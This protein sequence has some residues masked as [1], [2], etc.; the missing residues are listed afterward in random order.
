MS[1]TAIYVSAVL[2][3]FIYI[4]LGI[5]FS[6]AVFDTKWLSSLDKPSV[7]IVYGLYIAW[8]G[9]FSIKVSRGFIEHDIISTIFPI[10]AVIFIAWGLAEN[11]NMISRSEYFSTSPGAVVLFISLF[12]PYY[13]G[14]I[15]K[16]ILGEWKGKRDGKVSKRI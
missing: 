6:S 13:Y 4:I 2:Y 15:H 9:F 7:K 12:I 8:L 1:R 16:S 10:E 11:Y 14:N 3:M 5:A